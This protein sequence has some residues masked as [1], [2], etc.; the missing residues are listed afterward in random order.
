MKEQII[1]QIIEEKLK[2]RPNFQLVQK[3]QQLLDQCAVKTVRCDGV[4]HYPELGDEPCE[5]I[6]D[7]CKGV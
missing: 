7:D 5:N 2:D 1:N 4:K 3:L 6:C